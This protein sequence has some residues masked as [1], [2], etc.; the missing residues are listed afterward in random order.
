MGYNGTMLS[1]TI[2][3][4]VTNASASQ[5]YTFNIPQVIGSTTGYAGFTGGTGGQTAVQNIRTWTFTESTGASSASNNLVATP[6]AEPQVQL[7]GNENSPA[8]PLATGLTTTSFTD[9]SVTGGTTY[10]YAVT[11]VDPESLATTLVAPLGQS[12]P[13]GNVKVDKSHLRAF[14]AALEELGGAW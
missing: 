14:D 10:D 9:T 2:T 5:S 7:S 1:V 4:T 11:S 3:D 13:S 6:Q 12:G 8:T